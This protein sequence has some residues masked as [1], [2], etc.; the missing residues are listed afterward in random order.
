LKQEVREKMETASM[1]SGDSKGEKP[2]KK[3]IVSSPSCYVEGNLSFIYI[4]IRISS[5]GKPLSSR[6]GRVMSKLLQCM[7]AETCTDAT[8]F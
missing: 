5:C 1:P 7:L 4:R 3:S 6:C 8:F 2:G